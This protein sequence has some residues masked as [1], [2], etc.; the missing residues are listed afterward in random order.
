MCHGRNGPFPLT[1]GRSVDEKLSRSMVLGLYE[2]LD[3][4]PMHRGM[5]DMAGDPPRIVLFCKA[6]AQRCWC[7]REGKYWERP[8]EYSE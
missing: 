4:P 2:P 5:F 3:S 1:L 7:H 6:E 8:G